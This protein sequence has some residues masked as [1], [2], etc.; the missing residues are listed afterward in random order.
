[1]SSAK[2]GTGISQ[3]EITNIERL[4]FW[5]LAGDQEYFVPFDDYPAFQKATIQKIY[6]VK[7]LSPDQFHWPALDIDIELSALSE[8]HRFPL[9]YSP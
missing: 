3:Y 9:T 5:L 4:G 6:N 7:R 8:P 1:M 2:L